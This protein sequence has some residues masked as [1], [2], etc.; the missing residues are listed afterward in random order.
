MPKTHFDHDLLGLPIA[1][2]RDG[3]PD[4]IGPCGFFWLGGFKSDMMGSKAEHLATLASATR[5]NSLRFD[6]AGHG[7][8]AGLFVDG[9]ISLWLEQ[10]THMFLRHTRNQ[11]I[12]VGSSMGG[13]LALL[14]LKRL[15]QEDRNAARR[16]AGLVLLAPAADMT[17]DLMWDQFDDTRRAEL[18][19]RGLVQRPSDY[20]EPYTITLKLIEDGLRHLL[21]ADGL[22]VPC[23]VRILQGSDDTDVPPAHAVKTFEALRGSDITLSFIKGGDHRLSSAVQ[24]RI[25][26]ETVLGLADRADGIRP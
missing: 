23:P 25:L 18:A 17:H 5:R 22:D 12:I 19:D 9:T 11:R 8:S 2:C 26:S 10:A 1:F 15:M 7:Q 14:L 3:A 16:I 13:W 6:Y 20:G 4:D 24:L 21:L